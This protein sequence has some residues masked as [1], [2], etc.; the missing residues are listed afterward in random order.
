MLLDSFKVLSSLEKVLLTELPKAPELKE[1][2][3]LKNERFSYQIAC[4]LDRNEGKFLPPRWVSFE[5]KSDLAPY[6]TVREVGNVPSELPCIESETPDPEYSSKDLLNGGRP[7][8]YPDPLMP[9]DSNEIKVLCDSYTSLW[10]TVDTNGAVPAGKYAIDVIFT[11]TDGENVVKC[12]KSIEIEIIDALLPEQKLICTQWFHTDCIKDYY[13]VPEFSEEHWHYIDLFSKTAADNGINMILTPIFTPPLD[14]QVGGERTTVQ[15]VDISY[16]GKVYTF[17][18]SKLKRWFD[19]CLKNG[20]KYFEMAHLFTQWG[21]LY[22]PKIM[23]TVNGEYKRIFGWD[24]S[25]TSVEYRDFLSQFLPALTSFIESQG[26]KDVVYFHISDEP[27][28]SH[29]DAYKAAKAGVEKHLKGYNIIDAL[30]NLKFYNDGVVNIP[31]PNVRSTDE[32]YDAKVDPLWTYYCVSNTSKLSNRF[33]AY[34][35]WQTRVM[36]L[37][38]FKY[39]IAGFLQWGYNFYNTQYSKKHINPYQVTD[40]GRAFPS[41]DAFSVYPGDDC[42]IESLRLVVFNEGLQD[43]RAL[44][45]LSEKLGREKVCE[46]IDEIAGIKVTFDDYPMNSEFI[47]TLRNRVNELIKANI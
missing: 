2:S 36:G 10:I 25:A 14:T 11:N 29:L 19:M 46:L 7:G 34:P 15:L 37:Q 3:I 5:I 17:E 21:A 47:L 13:D 1:V 26:L 38:M 20:I 43:M 27:H 22:C 40:A 44:E 6:I 31:I 9:M 12:T 33:F 32:F 4:T 41:G 28:E 39:D 35:S 30:S 45:L 16:D 8:L 18:F 23:A 42:C 24:V